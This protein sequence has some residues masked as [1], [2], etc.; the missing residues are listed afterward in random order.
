L[1]PGQDAVKVND[2]PGNGV[3]VA[4]TGVA[5]NGVGVFVGAAVGTFVGTAVAGIGVGVLVGTA[6]G[7][8]VA[9]GTKQL[10]DTLLEP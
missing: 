1:V 4:G 10:V 2:I 9:V 3:T 8:G 6:V 7:I 5:G